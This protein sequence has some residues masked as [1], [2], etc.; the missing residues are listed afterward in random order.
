MACGVPSVAT[1]VG[2][3]PEV[4]TEVT[5]LLVEARDARALEAALHDALRRQ[6]DRD[7]IAR[8]ADQFTWEANTE[9]MCALIDRAIATRGDR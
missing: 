5:G 4:I 7:A 8:H 6:W 3:I 2:G 1:R 9:A